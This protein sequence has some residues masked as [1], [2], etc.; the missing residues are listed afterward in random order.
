MF[1]FSSEQ[2]TDR[3]D[4]QG[5]QAHTLNKEGVMLF[6]KCTSREESVIGLSKESFIHYCLLLTV[7]QCEFSV[8]IY[9]SQDYSIVLQKAKCILD[10]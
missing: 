4:S 9:D 8:P 3:G 10:A 2:R 7:Y 6:G 1:S 5:E